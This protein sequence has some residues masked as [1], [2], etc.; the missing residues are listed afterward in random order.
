MKAVDFLTHQEILDR[1]VDHLLRQG[2]AAL[3]P[4]GGGAYRGNCG[5]C[6]V[7]NFIRPQDHM[8][9]NERLVWCSSIE[10]RMSRSGKRSL[11]LQRR[12][13]CVGQWRNLQAVE[14]ARLE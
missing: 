5:G 2:R 14:M 8:S 12:Q 6:P 11:R 1:S 10:A 4:L 9:G 7:S 13:A 3:L